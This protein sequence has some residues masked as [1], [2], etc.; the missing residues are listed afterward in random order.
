MRRTPVLRSGAAIAVAAALA[1][2]GC[3][4]LERKA[5]PGPSTPPA[6]T[7]DGS[8]PDASL[9][10]GLGIVGGGAA[11]G[12]GTIQDGSLGDLPGGGSGLGPPSWVRPGMRLT[13]Y[14]AAASVPQSEY[15]YIEDEGGDWEDPVTGKR[16]RRT[17]QSGE[18]MPS[19]AGEAYTQTDVLAVDGTDVILSNT[20]YSIDLLAR[21]YVLQ[22]MGGGRSPGA[23]VDGAWVNPDLLAAAVQGGAQGMTVLRGPYALGGSQFDAVGFVATNDRGYQSSTF[24]A[25]SGVL[26]AMNASTQGAASPIHGPNDAPQGNVQL[27][28]SRFVGT[29]QLETPGID[30]PAP[31]WVA[32]VQGLEYEGTYTASNPMD[33]A[34]GP[35]V[36]PMAASIAF[37]D[38]GASWATFT[39][40]TT[41]SGDGPAQTTEGAGATGST[42][43]YWY[44]PATLAAMSTGQVLDQ[45][46]VTGA[47]TT[48]GSIEA[49][50]AG[51]VVHIVTALDGVSLDLAYDVMTGVLVAL[52]L[53]QAVTGATISLRLAPGSFPG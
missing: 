16:Y 21:Q 12:G 51:T 39:S 48:V 40:T 6:P 15:T 41:V 30:A 23:I 47:A 36:F 27:A 5:S 46:P 19:G 9:P 1:L 26:L 49:G 13:F 18:G 42:G 25:G 28:L 43:L 31:P 14:G 22:P 50:G 2:G 33:P 7:T 44:D 32:T 38:R 4:S 35:W 24:D 10:A 45:D 53:A 11:R 37:G 3:A 34:S 52:D 29:R 17:D 8:A 20:M